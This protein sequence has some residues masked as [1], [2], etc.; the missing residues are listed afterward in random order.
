VR[1]CLL[2]LA[3]TCGCVGASHGGADPDDVSSEYVQLFTRRDLAN[4]KAARVVMLPTN[5]SSKERELCVIKSGDGLENLI[6]VLKYMTLIKLKTSVSGA[7]ELDLG[8]IRLGH[9]SSPAK[10]KV[11]GDYV[12]NWNV[13]VDLDGRNKL[14][15]SNKRDHH[16]PYMFVMYKGSYYIVT[17]NSEARVS[18][19]FY[20]RSSFL[21]TFKGN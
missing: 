17:K 2:F 21:Q 16:H 6:H 10:I 8:G 7:D 11:D 1:L 3:L 19:I 15:L 5:D 12:V 9:R 14:Y 4:I 20:C 13:Y 18:S